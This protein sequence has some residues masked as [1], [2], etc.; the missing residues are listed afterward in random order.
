MATILSKY[1]HTHRMFAKA[2]D[3][4]V[5]TFT[6]RLLNSSYTFSAAHTVWTSC[7]SAEVANGS[8]YTTGGLTLTC[9]STNSLIKASDAL[10]TSVTKTFRSGVIVRNGTANGLTDALV[11]HFLWNDSSGG[12]DII[13]DGIDFLVR[14]NDGLFTL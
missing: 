7:S 14:L 3:W 9:S 11:C 5:D 4:D 12:T 10:W 13:L 6:L 2:W 8:G 1:S